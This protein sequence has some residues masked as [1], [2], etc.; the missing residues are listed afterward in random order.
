MVCGGKGSLLVSRVRPT[1]IKPMLVPKGQE[2]RVGEA[3]PELGW[4]C[5]FVSDVLVGGIE[6]VG[7]VRRCLEWEEIFIG[8]LVRSGREGVL[9]MEEHV[10]GVVGC[11][12]AGLGPKVEEDCIGFPAAKGTDGGRVNAGD[13]ESSG[14]TGA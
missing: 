8:V 4:V 11:E 9:S 12:G 1:A 7:Q 3:E 13:E 2:E 10:S 5:W 14:A 6:C